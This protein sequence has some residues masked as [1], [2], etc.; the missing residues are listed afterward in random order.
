MPGRVC[1]MLDCVFALV[2][3]AHVGIPLRA[4]IGRIARRKIQDLPENNV[5]ERASVLARLAVRSL[6]AKSTRSSWRHG[7]GPRAVRPGFAF[8][9]ACRP[10]PRA[11]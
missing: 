3:V 10:S 9:G 5:V 2:I 8:G 4:A 11:I 7:L 6:G 1:C